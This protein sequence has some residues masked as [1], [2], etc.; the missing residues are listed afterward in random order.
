[1]LDILNARP[2]RMS[3]KI[4]DAK[5]EELYANGTPTCSATSEETEI[6]SSFQT[7]QNLCY[8]H[9]DLSLMPTRRQT[10]RFVS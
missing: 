9:S 3:S 6:F 8:L 2:P 7:T 4:P 5:S 1:M 10:W